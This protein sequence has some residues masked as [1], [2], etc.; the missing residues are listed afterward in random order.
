[1]S[2]SLYLRAH[3][4]DVK[5]QALPDDGMCL[6]VR[7]RAAINA[8]R[9]VRVFFNDGHDFD[10][11]IRLVVEKTGQT[12]RS[13]Q[14]SRPARQQHRAATWY[15]SNRVRHLRLQLVSLSDFTF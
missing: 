2:I 1:M 3:D 12:V 15:Q 11:S 13:T 6:K 9:P 10:R 7:H 14:Q 8:A 4:L 5:S